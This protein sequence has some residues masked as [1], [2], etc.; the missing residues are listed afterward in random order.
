MGDNGT[1]SSQGVDRVNMTQARL[2]ALGVADR[3]EKSLG[4][5]QL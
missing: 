5:G 1:V 3:M 4:F 2:I